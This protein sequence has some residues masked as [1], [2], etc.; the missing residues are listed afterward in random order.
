M[1]NPFLR[2]FSLFKGNS[3]G[4]STPRR[5]PPS[6]ATASAAHLQKSYH[7]KDHVAMLVAML[8]DR[9]H[10][11]PLPGHSAS[12]RSFTGRG[13]PSLPACRPLPCRVIPSGSALG[14]V[15][16]AWDEP[17]APSVNVTGEWDTEMSWHQHA[18]GT[19]AL[20]QHL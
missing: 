9:S 4:A 18:A 14:A 12:S 15:L 5:R 16:E 13:P 7:S 19:G 2:A 11:G 1:P 6:P 8:L 3:A 17:I 10:S 20:L